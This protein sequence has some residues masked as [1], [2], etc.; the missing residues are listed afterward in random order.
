ML[1]ADLRILAYIDHAERRSSWARRFGRKLGG[2]MLA[3]AMTIPVVGEAAA[4]H[5]QVD[6][7]VGHHLARSTPVRFGD[8]PVGRGSGYSPA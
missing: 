4:E 3:H 7:A 8:R 1:R 6:T 5:D 2:L